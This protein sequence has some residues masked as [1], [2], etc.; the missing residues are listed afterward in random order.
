MAFALA[1]CSRLVPEFEIG[2]NNSGSADRQAAADRQRPLA[3][4]SGA[5]VRR[6]SGKAWALDHDKVLGLI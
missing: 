2:K 4:M 1:I 5:R 3:M 6:W